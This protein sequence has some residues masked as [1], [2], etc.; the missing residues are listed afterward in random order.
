MQRFQKWKSVCPDSWFS[1]QPNKNG[2]LPVDQ[3]LQRLP[4][5]FDVINSIL[6]EMKIS[7]HGYLE[8]VKLLILSRLG[9]LYLILATLPM[10]NY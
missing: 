7:Q 1:C 9:Y 3:P 6:D 2:F 10:Y 4:E 5:Q 8:K